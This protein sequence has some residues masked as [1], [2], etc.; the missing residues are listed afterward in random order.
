VR[1][2]SVSE[3]RRSV[4][5]EVDGLAAP[6]LV[7]VHAVGPIVDEARRELWSTEA[8]YTL[9]RLPD[10]KGEV[11]APPA[12]AHNLLTEDETQAGWRLLFDGAT[13]NGWH[14]Y[15]KSGAP[16]GWKVVD[17]ALTRT[18]DGG[19][20]LVTDEEFESFELSLEWKI[21][22]G[23]NSGVLFHVAD[24]YDYVWRTG[25]EM[26]IL[27]DARH[28]DGR[29]PLT[30]AGANYALHAPERD[31]TF[32]VGMWN[33]ARIL[34]DGAHVEHWLNG[35]KQCEYELWSADWRARVAASKFATMP[36]Y[37]KFAR[38]RIALQDHGDAV[39][40][41]D[42]KLRPIVKN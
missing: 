25:P 10:A 2:S 33:R 39:A 17:G 11:R 35:V 8:W 36:D 18:N 42:V 15:G 21:G 34:V 26:Q 9:N 19:A 6:S 12:R 41:R 31:D 30:S 13:A 38:G 14:E 22:A 20:D 24:G 1:S 23:G 27:D 29:N 40:F 7:H 28:R 5:V 3:D 4:F 16:I 37:G 32:P